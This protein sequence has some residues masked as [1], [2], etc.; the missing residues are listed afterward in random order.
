MRKLSTLALLFAALLGLAG[1]AAAAT[2]GFKVV[3]NK[4]N[5]TRGLPK[6]KIALMFMKMS[7]KWESGTAVEPVDQAAAAAVRATFSQAIHNRDVDAIKAAWQRAVF[8]GRGEP[9]LEKA[10]D[11]EVVAFVASH[12]GAI[13]Y[14]SEAAPV[15]K[16]KVLDVLN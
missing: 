7:T 2:A 9:P 14:V 15:D 6:A 13:G 3:V 4:E 5:P 11:E 16:V 10:S 12:P 8:A 1:T